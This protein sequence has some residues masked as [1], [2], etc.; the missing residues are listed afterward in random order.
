MHGG[1]TGRVTEFDW[2]PN[3]PWLMLAAAE[4]NQMQIFRPA[5]SLVNVA[6]KKNVSMREVEE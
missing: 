6:P 5:R 1:F 3:D 2:N 4:D